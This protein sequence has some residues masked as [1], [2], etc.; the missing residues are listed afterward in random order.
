MKKVK[1]SDQTFQ[2]ENN[3]GYSDETIASHFKNAVNEYGGGAEFFAKEQ[4]VKFSAHDSHMAGEK[5]KF[6]PQ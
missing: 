5:F 3:T 6:I 1:I 2:I 4:G